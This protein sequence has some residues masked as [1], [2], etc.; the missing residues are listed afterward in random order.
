MWLTSFVPRPRRDA[1]T[2]GDEPVASTFWIAAGRLKLT[3]GVR[4]DAPITEVA[5][6]NGHTEADVYLSNG[7]KNQEFGLSAFRF[8]QN[9]VRVPCA[10]SNPDSPNAGDCSK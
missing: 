9:Q 4:A 6:F 3:G 7:T 8:P 10:R 1:G 2:A 5:T